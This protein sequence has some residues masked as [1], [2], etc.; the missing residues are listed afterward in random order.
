[1]QKQTDASH[2]LTVFV[3]HWNRPEECARTVRA[4]CAQDFPVAVKVIDNASNEDSFRSL[5]SSLPSGVAV[6]RLREN[7]GWGPALNVVLKEWLSSCE[8][9]FCAISAHDAL[10]GPGCLRLLVESMRQDPTTGITCPEYGMNE[11]PCFSRLRYLRSKRLS[12]GSR[13]ATEVV[14]VPHGT[15]MLVRKKCLEDIGLFDERYFA[16]GDEHELGL[17]A[18][19]HGWK[20]T[21]V[22]GAEVVNPGTWTSTALR[23]YLFTRNSLLLIQTYGG[24]WSASL[25]FLL[26]I[27]NTLRM[28]C[29]PPNE[30][31]AFSARARFLAMCDFLR[32]RYGPPPQLP[33]PA[34]SPSRDSS[35]RMAVESSLH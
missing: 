14:D 9:E 21:M 17:R 24:T 20:V 11:V 7:L 29:V 1:M 30:G 5:V 25:R 27:P 34:A 3:L 23:S 16:Y 26:M 35:E 18:G 31:Y 22:W 19:R 32:G 13:G 2:P 33:R 15:L 28:L 4:F 6:T 8:G 10:P 12:R